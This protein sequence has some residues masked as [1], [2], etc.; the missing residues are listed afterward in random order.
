MK[1]G[2]LVKFESNSWVMKRGDYANPGLILED[3]S[4]LHTPRYR[5]LWA[6]QKIT[7]EHIGYLVLL[8][9]R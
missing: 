3:V 5:V 6:N 9:K 8:A 1:V 4:G 2:D 7:V